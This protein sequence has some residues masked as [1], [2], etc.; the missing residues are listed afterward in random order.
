M[1]N[2]LHTIGVKLAVSTSGAGVLQALTKGLTGVSLT[3]R[4][5]QL[6]LS[7]I[8]RG[9]MLAVG[10]M[11]ALGAGMLVLK[12]LKGPLDAAEQWQKSVANLQLFNMGD[13]ANDQAI[14][15]AKGMNIIG[16]SYTDNLNMMREAIGT[17]RDSA[18]KDP[19]GNAEMVAPMMAKMRMIDST[20]GD[21]TASRNHTQE[22]AML[23]FAE[24]TGG[25]QSKERMTSLLNSGFKAIQSAP[26]G[27]M[28]WEAL[29]QFKTRAGASGFNLSDEALFSYG[30]PLIAELK[31]STA[32]TSLMTAYQRANGMSAILPSNASEKFLSMGL[33]DKND[34][35]I[36]AR[37][38]KVKNGDNP[39][40]DA[41]GY[42]TNPFKWYEDNVHSYYEKNHVSAAD[43][44]RDNTLLFGRTGGNLFN[45]TE[46]QYGTMLKSVDAQAKMQNIDGSY[47]TASKTILGMK[48]DTV[49]QFKDLMIT[50]GNNLIPLV[51]SGLRVLNPLL[52]SFAQ[53][54]EK[55][56][57][58]SKALVVGTALAGVLLTVA[59]PIIALAGAFALLAPLFAA[60]GVL[61]GV[62]AAIAG[63]ATPIG[64]GV[65]AIVGS[66]G[67]IWAL[68][69]LFGFKPPSHAVTP[70]QSA[71]AEAKAAADKKKNDDWWKWYNSQ[72]HNK[73]HGVGQPGAAAATHAGW[74]DLWRSATGWMGD[75]EHLTEAKMALIKFR[76]DQAAKAKAAA[77]YA[78]NAPNRAYAANA[79]NGQA[80]MEKWFSDHYHAVMD[81]IL[82]NV[83]ESRV[84]M[85][86]QA[87]LDEGIL[88]F[89]SVPPK[90]PIV[91][92]QVTVAPNGQQT[93]KTTYGATSGFNGHQ[94]LPAMV[95]GATNR[96]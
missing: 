82:K 31:G 1:T 50:F 83:Q 2:V 54:A 59:G 61:A 41:A 30:E 9:A 13:V 44:Y 56:P 34:V 49:T 40:V 55:H 64:I 51:S 4:E 27:Q 67:L 89:L 69:Q 18:S 46:R 62:G 15:F 76:E 20:L 25:L 33:W 90:P 16:S 93:V 84:M 57:I 6:A 79:G 35:N 17:F 95:G 66:G 23:R 91:N 22:I 26:G 92:V 78:N 52:H 94:S 32:G 42:S 29:R 65:A 8:H 85:Q 96:R 38:A 68:H 43:R 81:G 3:A 63:L 48:A 24:L 37:G 47:G 39:L 58:M 53:W 86:K 14:K 36:T 60:G 45:V 87:S 5:A 7:G 71:A 10:G 80:N 77:D 72:P 12:G 19:L 74:G 11:A 73:P 88:R 21:D 28:N 70:E 75:S